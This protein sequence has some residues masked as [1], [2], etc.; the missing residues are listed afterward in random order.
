[1]ITIIIEF[2]LKDNRAL[3][4]ALDPVAERIFADL[5]H[6]DDKVDAISEELHAAK[7]TI[8]RLEVYFNINIF[9][10]LY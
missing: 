3:R 4:K 2:H 9:L 10:F 1:M 8:K 5:R 7:E 6:G